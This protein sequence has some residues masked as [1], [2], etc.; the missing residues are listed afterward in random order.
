MDF[1]FV[2]LGQKTCNYQIFFVPLRWICVSPT[3]RLTGGH[4]G[5][6]SVHGT[7][8]TVVIILFV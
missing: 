4:I 6:G 7:W 8:R 2:L 1:F 5:S 3:C